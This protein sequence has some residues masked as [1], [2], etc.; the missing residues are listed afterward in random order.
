MPLTE[1]IRVLEKELATLDQAGT[2][3]GKEIV[4][5]GV[6]RAEGKRGTRYL[7]G[8]YGD[9]EFLRMNSNSYLG[10]ALDDEVIAAEEAAAKAFGAGPGAARFISGTFQPHVELENRLA[11]FHKREAGI[12]F[13]SGYATVLGVLVPLFTKDTIVIS[14][15]LN[16]N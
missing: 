4:I 5:T 15:E 16:H 3:K 6:K 12:L 13:S 8:G 1:I 14:D 7:I 9:K 11:L 10:L 2:R